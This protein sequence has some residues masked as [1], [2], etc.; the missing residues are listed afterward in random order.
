MPVPLACF[1]DNGSP[2]GNAAGQPVRLDTFSRTKNKKP[3]FADGTTH[4]QLYCLDLTICYG[5]SILIIVKV[6]LKLKGL[7]SVWER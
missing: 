3:Y 2:R 4:G 5:D 6:L 1:P 7:E